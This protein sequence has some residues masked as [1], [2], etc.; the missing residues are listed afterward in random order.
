MNRSRATVPAL[1][2]AAAL[3]AASPL[4]L[5]G[6]PAAAAAGAAPGSASA[7]PLRESVLV[8]GTG[9]VLGEP[10][11]LTANFAVETVA[12]TVDAALDQASA[13]ATRMRDSLAGAGVAKADLQTSNVTVSSRQNDDHKITGYSANQEL[14]ATIRNLSRAGKLMSAA[15]AAGG[16]AARLN[17][18]SFAVENDDAL[19]DEARRKAFAAARS[20]AEL[21][22]RAAGRPLGRVLRVSEETPGLYGGSGEHD[23]M[24]AVAD[25]AVPVEPGRQRLA[26]TVT[27]EWALQPAP[28]TTAPAA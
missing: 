8:S 14:T 26:V 4:L 18:V 11:T 22:A 21:Y 2:V 25:F 28:G 6:Q 5:A 15:I 24:A 10:D 19:L 23:K 27:V 12:S 13:T 1:V 16:D 17:G 3:A 7:E 20:K 9:E